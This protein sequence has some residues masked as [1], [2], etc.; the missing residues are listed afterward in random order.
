MPKFKVLSKVHCFGFKGRN[1][2]PGELVEASEEDAAQFNLDYL[3]RVPDP[4]SEM[5]SA[6]DFLNMKPV[7]FSVEMGPEVKSVRVSTVD[8]AEVVALLAPE[9]KVDAVIVSEKTL[10]KVRSKVLP[11]VP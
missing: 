11:K 4:I 9:V 10:K 5:T 1:Y 6:V 2:L 7:V 3:E 8:V